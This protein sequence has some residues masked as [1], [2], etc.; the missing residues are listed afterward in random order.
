MVIG[1]LGKVYDGSVAD[2]GR[3][4]TGL[5]H[6]DEHATFRNGGRATGGDRKLT[7]W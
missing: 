4:Q 7:A 5:D 1:V 2:D 6:G 3:V